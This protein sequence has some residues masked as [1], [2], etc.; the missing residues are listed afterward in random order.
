[1]TRPVAGLDLCNSPRYFCG[2]PLRTGV[3][4]AVG[5]RSSYEFG[6]CLE[7][8]KP[9]GEAA[10]L[11]LVIAGRV[12]RDETRQIE[13][14]HDGERCGSVEMMEPGLGHARRI[15]DVMHP[16]G[17]DQEVAIQTR[18]ASRDSSS[19]AGNAT[20]V[21]PALRLPDQQLLG[22]GRSRTRVQ[23]TPTL[24]RRRIT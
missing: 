24:S 21:R 8:G 14:P 22:P 3:K 13:F 17:C 6:R 4:I 10:C 16:R 11:G 18:D 1:M 2:N 19:Y 23:H 12:M 7:A 9:C 5:Q 15:P 20:R